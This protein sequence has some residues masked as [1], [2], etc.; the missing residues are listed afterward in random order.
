MLPPVL[1]AQDSLAK[2]VEPSYGSFGFQG[3]FVSGTGI[4]GGYTRNRFRV[5]VTYGLLKLENET[6]YSYGVDMHYVLA[7]KP[8]FLVLI[9][10]SF[11]GYGTSGGS[12][13]VRLAFATCV[14]VPALGKEINESIC[15]GVALYYPTYYFV[16]HTLNPTGGIYLIYNF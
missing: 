7:V 16:S 4:T 11:G 3:S 15:V 14:E 5:R 10:P 6:D 13:K 1:S 2:K 12:D 8:Q 9:G